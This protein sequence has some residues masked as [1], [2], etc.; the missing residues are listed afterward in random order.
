MNKLFLKIS[1]FLLCFM[2]AVFILAGVAAFGTS[3]SKH[4]PYPRAHY[5]RPYSV[6]EKIQGENK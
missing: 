4:S 5:A 3:Y 6:M 1:D 2:G